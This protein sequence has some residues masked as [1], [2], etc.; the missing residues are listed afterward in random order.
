[1]RFSTLLVLVAAPVLSA[2]GETRLTG[3][4]SGFVF[5]APSR[6]IRPILGIPG[7]AYLGAALVSDVDLAAVSAD[8]KA[9]LAVR[10]GKLFEA[11]GLDSGSP[12][13]AEIEGAIGDATRLAWSRNSGAAAVYSAGS[14]RLQLFARNGR[15]RPGEPIG[16]SGDVAALAVEDSGERALVAMESENGDG[17]Y[18]AEPG[19]GTRLVAPVERIGGLAL[20]D[21]RAF[22][23]DR[24]RNQ[25]LE[26]RGYA[27]AGEVL[28]FASDATGIGDPIALAVSADQ[29]R[30][31]AAGGS[32]KDVAVFDLESRERTALL[33]MDFEA[34]GM[35]PLSPTLFLLKP[36]NAEGEPIQVLEAGLHPAVYFVPARSG[37]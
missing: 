19:A 16:I 34:A 33:T 26:I 37:N 14:R 9:A 27:T 17:V 1:V 30:L 32:G 18:V 36:A 11:R 13:L 6:A 7:A 28:L 23:G 8:G 2:A 21:G 22:A 24:G 25:I 15:L 35:E 29:R 5:D 12:V 4:V 20:G 31:F 3:P 10:G